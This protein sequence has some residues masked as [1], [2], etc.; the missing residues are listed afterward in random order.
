VLCSLG[1]LADLLGRKQMSYRAAQAD[2]RQR[3]CVYLCLAG[4]SLPRCLQL[5]FCGSL[6]CVIVHEVEG[7][8]RQREICADRLEVCV[9]VYYGKSR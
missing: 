6:C 9:C 2:N 7:T 5:S 1:G 3:F 4:L 8:L